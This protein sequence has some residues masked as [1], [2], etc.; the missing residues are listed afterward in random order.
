ME[1]KM[2]PRAVV[3]KE[4]SKY[5]LLK[6]YTDDF[7]NEETIARSEKFQEFQESLVGT[8][9]LPYYVIMGPDKKP[10]YTHKDYQPDE[11]KFV[12]FLR[13]SDEYKVAA[14]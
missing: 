5:V 3:R 14:R 10:I 6:I 1:E 9:S 8:V 12:A 11:A 2:F 13:Q 7:E 4:L